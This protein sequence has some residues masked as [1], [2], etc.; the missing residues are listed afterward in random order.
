MFRLPITYSNGIENAWPSSASSEYEM[1]KLCSVTSLLRMSS[2]IS[3][4]IGSLCSRPA[5]LA[6]AVSPA[7]M[8]NVGTQLTENVSTWSA[9]RKMMT[10]G[11]VSSRTLPSSFIDRPAWSSCSGF[12]SGGRVNMY[13]VW[14]VP[15]AATISPIG[16]L[17]S[18]VGRVGRVGLV[19]RNTRTRLQARH[20]PRSPERSDLPDPSDPPDPPDLPDLL[21]VYVPHAE[22]CELRA[23]PVEV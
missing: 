15:T 18:R 8:Q 14:H 11:F 12:S 6:C 3:R 20:T 19:G 21:L 7:T 17:P 22:L 13:G 4:W 1:S 5:N 9:P 23:E 16:C 10:S 2:A